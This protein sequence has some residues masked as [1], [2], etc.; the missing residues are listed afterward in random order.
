[1]TGAGRI[2]HGAP[3][4]FAERVEDFIS[5]SFFS[6]VWPDEIEIT[7]GENSE[8]IFS[9]K[10][11]IKNG[12]DPFSPMVLCYKRST[13]SANGSTVPLVILYF[14]GIMLCTAPIRAGVFD[15]IT[16]TYDELKPRAANNP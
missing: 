11:R 15:G 1:V 4:P 5:Q 2:T 3:E 7:H 8:K 9:Q 13:R 14:S 10:C 16:I 6:L 12:R